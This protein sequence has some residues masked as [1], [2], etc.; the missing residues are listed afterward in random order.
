MTTLLIF[1]DKSFT[2]YAKPAGKKNKKEAEFKFLDKSN[3]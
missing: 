3:V 2:G 1:C